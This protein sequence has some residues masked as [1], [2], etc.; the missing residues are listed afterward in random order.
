MVDL[1]FN[2]ANLKISHPIMAGASPLSE[3]LDGIKRLEDAEVSA[4]FL[5]SLFEEQIAIE[6]GALEHYLKQGTETYSESISY[7]PSIDEFKSSKEEY[8]EKIRK[9]KDSISVP[10][11]ANLNGVTLGSWASLAKDIE[12]A[13][14]DGIELNFY[15]VPTKIDQ[16]SIEIENN[17]IEI[18]K[19]IKKEV[20]IPVFL[21]LSP[22]FTS[23][24]YIAKRF[25]EAGANGLVLFNR[26]YQ[27][28]VDLENLEVEKKLELSSSS[29]NKEA[30]R[31]ISI[32]YG[33]LK[34]SLIGTGGI[35]T[36][37]DILKFIFV[38]VCGV[39]IVSALL[40]EGLGIV[41]K[42]KKE[43]ENWL[44]EKEYSSIKECM[45]VLSQIKCPNPSAFERSNYMKIL[46]NYKA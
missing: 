21:K 12:S 17:F 23:I 39:Q 36:S 6:N 1:S 14:A 2:L 3:N 34:L 26:F 7:F 28:E 32:L 4:I 10:I 15:F 43:I 11:I 9:A 31:F 46:L 19:E 38:G 24:P 5:H 18:V 20:K 44:E 22:F 13:G 35:W 30:I 40:K 8:L 29:E 27:P 33:R 16:S 25:E 41:K 37:Q 45:G 42:L